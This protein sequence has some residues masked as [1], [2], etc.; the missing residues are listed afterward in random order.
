MTVWL[1]LL[2]VI[3]K[4]KLLFNHTQISTIAFVE[5]VKRNSMP[6]KM[7]K[8]FSG[9]GGYCI[10]NPH[11]ASMGANVV[12]DP[13]I[14]TLGQGSM[15]AVVSF[16]VNVVEHCLPYTKCAECVKVRTDARYVIRNEGCV[17]GLIFV[18]LLIL[19]IH[20]TKHAS[21]RECVLVT[22]RGAYPNP[23]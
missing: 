3:I 22:M 10:C 6:R 8:L 5:N 23:V 11:V 2:H 9:V 1:A 7:C 15:G 20:V 21:T 18:Y 14:I 17:R 19:I 13:A 12:S 4:K 16:F